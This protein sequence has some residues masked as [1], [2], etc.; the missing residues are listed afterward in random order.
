MSLLVRT[1]RSF[2]CS[3]TRTSPTSL[4]RIRWAAASIDVRASI[5]SGSRCITS[6]T[7]WAIAVPLPKG[8]SPT[9][10]GFPIGQRAN[11]VCARNRPRPHRAV[12][13]ASGG[14]RS[15]QFVQVSGQA[16]AGLLVDG[17]AQLAEHSEV[18]QRA[19]ALRDLGE[20][21]G[22]PGGRQGAGVGSEDVDL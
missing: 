17:L 3:V 2:P 10:Q 15:Q 13:A 19:Q 22:F 11:T 18:G 21:R 4:A 20:P 6:F 7:S 12:R 5:T 1:P 16:P 14:G 9:A 8:C